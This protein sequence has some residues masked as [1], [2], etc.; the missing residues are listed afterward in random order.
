[1][2]AA[3]VA[4]NLAQFR[5]QAERRD[6]GGYCNIHGL[7]LGDACPECPYETRIADQEALISGLE[8]EL[9][10]LNRHLAE[11]QSERDALAALVDDAIRFLGVLD[12]REA[13]YTALWLSHAEVLRGKG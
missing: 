8:A 12:G 1:V 6:H 2:K 9:A 10:T 3:E 4:K 11:I 5:Q 7:H 13:E